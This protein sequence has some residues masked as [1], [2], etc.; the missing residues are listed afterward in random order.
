MAKF[1]RRKV[2]K[3]K[4]YRRKK[5][6]RRKGKVRYDAPVKIVMSYDEEVTSPNVAAPETSTV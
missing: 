2:T 5:S 1:R 4:V 3:K 6:Y